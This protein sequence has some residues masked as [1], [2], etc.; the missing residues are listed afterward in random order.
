MWHALLLGYVPGAP[1]LP[2]HPTVQLKQVIFELL[3]GHCS[4]L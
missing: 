4:L 1:M 3:G 2:A